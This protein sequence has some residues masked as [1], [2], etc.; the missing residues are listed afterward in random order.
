MGSRMPYVWCARLKSRMRSR[1]KLVNFY[2]WLLRNK[3]HWMK[4]LYWFVNE[5]VLRRASFF[6]SVA[7]V[8]CP[9]FSNVGA[10]T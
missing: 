8:T 10:R 2:N 5:F 3:Q 4:Y 1:A 7:L 6:I 9:S